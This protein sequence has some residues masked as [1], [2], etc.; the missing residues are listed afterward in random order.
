MK[1]ILTAIPVVAMAALFM[2][3]T[4]CHSEQ[5]WLAKKKLDRLMLNQAQQA[6][7]AVFSS[8]FQRNWSRLH[9]LT[10]GRP[11]SRSLE[12]YSVRVR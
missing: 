8:E 1:K 2:G 3:A 10:W 5:F 4:L 7:I 12:Q 6:E 11:N 9:L